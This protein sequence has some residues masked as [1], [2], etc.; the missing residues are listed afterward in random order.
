MGKIHLNAT[1]STVVGFEIYG[2]D[3]YCGLIFK[4]ADGTQRVLYARENGVG[5]EKR[6]SGGTTTYW[7]GH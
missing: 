5:Y 1:T 7:S 6:D 4:H 2:Q 3:D